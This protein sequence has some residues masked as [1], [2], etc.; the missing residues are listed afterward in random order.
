LRKKFFASLFGDVYHPSPLATK[1]DD[2]LHMPRR[3]RAWLNF[4][5]FDSSTT[6]KMAKTR[7]VRNRTSMAV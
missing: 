4:R 2:D 6:A 3:A 5:Q 7:K 1:K